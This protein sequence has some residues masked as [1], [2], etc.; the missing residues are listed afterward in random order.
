MSL[1]VHKTHSYNMNIKFSYF[2]V[3]ACTPR[4]TLTLLLHFLAWMCC[5]LNLNEEEGISISSLSYLTYYI[6]PAQHNHFLSWDIICMWPWWLLVVVVPSSFH[7]TIKKRKK[8]ER[9][10]SHDM[11]LATWLSFDFTKCIFWYAMHLLCIL[12]PL[13][14]LSFYTRQ[15]TL[16]IQK[17]HASNLEVLLLQS[18]LDITSRWVPPTSLWATYVLMP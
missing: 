5:Q 14:Q 11:M 8:E 1:H 9:C 18:P 10:K 13:S 7:L 12:L 3:N 6:S 16:I 2:M 15:T 17:N 4:L